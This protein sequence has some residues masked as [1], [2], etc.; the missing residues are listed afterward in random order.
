MRRSIS[1]KYSKYCP[2]LATPQERIAFC[3]L[4]ESDLCYGMNDAI[5]IVPLEALETC[6]ILIGS[7]VLLRY[8]LYVGIHSFRIA[9]PN[10]I[11][12]VY[13]RCGICLLWLLTCNA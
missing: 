3:L 5:P 9:D 4:V 12:M 1:S 6:S 13:K 2:G 7:V 11:S 8:E 10:A